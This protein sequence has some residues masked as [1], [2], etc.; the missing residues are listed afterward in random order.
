MERETPVCGPWVSPTVTSADDLINILI[1]SSAISITIYVNV[2]K[3]KSK[4]VEC[5]LM[6]YGENQNARNAKTSCG[7]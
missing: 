3:I 1:C 5:C 2:N 6:F 7:N 4:T